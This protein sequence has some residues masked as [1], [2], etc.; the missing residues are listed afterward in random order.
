[1]TPRQR[2]NV[3]PSKADALATQPRTLEHAQ[4][5]LMLAGALILA[6]FS[7][8]CAHGPAAAARSTVACAATSTW[9]EPASRKTVPA[10]ALI[11]RA[12]A[13]DIVLLGEAHDDADHHRWQL[14]TLAAIHGRRPAMVI[15][16]EML[17][18]S[19]QAALDLWVAGTL[20][21]EDFLVA[22]NWEKSWGFD[23][24]LYMPLFHF[25][26]LHRIPVVALN[27]ERTLVARVARDGWASVPIAARQG[28]GDPAPP[29]DAY[30]QSL[31]G[32]FGAH[33]R[34]PNRAANQ[35]QDRGSG[36]ASDGRL[37]RFIDAQLIWD[38][39]MAEAISAAASSHPGAVVVAIAGTGHLAH[40]WGIPHQLADL[41]AP[42]I[43]VL[44]PVAQ[45]DTCALATDLADAVYVFPPPA[46]ATMKSDAYR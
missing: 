30:R 7:A 41:D 39:A 9:L 3:S 35:A 15:G 28:V 21:E 40:R 16:V 1:M 31:K 2:Q 32:V 23:P 42:P 27:V 24:G 45:A 4:R 13:A 43:I 5:R 20:S 8:G 33:T 29:A 44:L 14:H 6:A 25:A 22:V 18:R 37:A 17:P 26:R 10:D 19:A 12:A 46:G 38:R 34:E 36:G 11:A